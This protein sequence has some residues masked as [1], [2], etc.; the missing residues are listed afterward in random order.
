M[1]QG[2]TDERVAQVVAAALADAAVAKVRPPPSA[3]LAACSWVPSFC[4]PRFCNAAQFADGTACVKVV[5]LL[6]I[7]VRLTCADR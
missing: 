2:K 5:L 7:D 1:L 6:Q 3:C 4:S